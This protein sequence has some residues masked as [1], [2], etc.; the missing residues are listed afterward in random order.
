LLSNVPYVPHLWSFTQGELYDSQEPATSVEIY[1]NV[2]FYYDGE[3]QPV[4]RT[5]VHSVIMP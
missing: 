5:L 2:T 1:Q 3:I 4:R